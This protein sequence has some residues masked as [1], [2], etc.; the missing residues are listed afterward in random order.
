MRE[1]AVQAATDTLNNS[2][3]ASIDLEYQALKN[4][5]SRIANATQYNEMNILNVKGIS[6]YEQEVANAKQTMEAAQTAKSDAETTLSQAK[7]T[8]TEAQAG[9]SSSRITVFSQAQTIFGDTMTALE[10]VVPSATLVGRTIKRISID[11]NGNEGNNSS[12]SPNLSAD[13]RY[14]AFYSSASNLVDNDTNEQT[15][16]FVASNP[17]AS[18]TSLTI[19]TND[20]FLQVQT[21]VASAK[22]AFDDVQATLSSPE[23]SNADIVSALSS[24]ETFLDDA[25]SALN[26][27]GSEDIES[28]DLSSVLTQFNSLKTTYGTISTTLQDAESQLTQLATD[29]GN[30]ESMLATRESQRATA[31]TALTEAET[32]L[33]SAN[34]PS[35]RTF[36]IG[37]DNDINNQLDFNLVDATTEAIGVDGTDVVNLGSARSSITALDHATDIINGERSR[38]GSIQNELQFTMSNLNSNIQSIEAARSSIQDTDFAADAADLGKNQILAQSATAMLAQASAIPQNILSLIAA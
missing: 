19:A 12:Q 14:V 28:G 20:K 25:I 1:L 22:T 21:K 17:L 16:I 15:D 30:A 35:S 26:A 32:T 5:V 18:E 38:L 36:Q 13:G 24:A 8:L 11:S 6:A 31:Q 9:I 4:E 29:V 2:D 27:L 7:I 3:R 34:N 37:A 33:A 10:G 23:V